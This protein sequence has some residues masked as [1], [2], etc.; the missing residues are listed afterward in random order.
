MNKNKIPIRFKVYECVT[1]LLVLLPIVFMFLD[2][3]YCWTNLSAVVYLCASACGAAL[4][5]TTI[6]AKKE[7]VAHNKTKRNSD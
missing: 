4:L 1:V 3:F 5:I 6:V 2:F 7:W